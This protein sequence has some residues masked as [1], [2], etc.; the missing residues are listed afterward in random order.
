M[1]R[2]A[3]WRPALRIARRDLS[4]S[5]GRSSLVAV[6]VGLP[7]FLVST[8]ATVYTTSSLTPVEMLPRQLG[9][10]QAIVEP[11]QRGPIDQVPDGTNWQPV[12]QDGSS[13]ATE[14]W[15]LAQVRRAVA[16][17]VLDV[18]SAAG[19]VRTTS[20]RLAV[21]V[22]G[23]DITSPELTGYVQL[24]SGRM[25][26][27]D[28]EALVSPWLA[29]RG[30]AIGR[31]VEVV[32]SVDAPD[33][34]RATAKVVGVGLVPSLYA[35]AVVVARPTSP[36]VAVPD[37]EVAH[38]YLIAGS[39]PV[40]WP[41]VRE[42]N[43]VGLLVTSRSVVTNPPANWE[44]SLSR[45]DAFSGNGFGNNGNRAVL[46]I[47]VFS[48][49][50][51][52][53]LLAGPAFAVGVRRQRRHL[54]LVAAS[55]GTARDVRRVVLVQAL[56]TGALAAAVGAAAG[57]PAAW[58]IVTL[59]P[60]VRP[61]TSL[62]PFDVAGLPVLV[63]AA[64]G[65]V[66]AVTAAYFPAR[67][68]AR[69]DVVAVLAGRRGQ[70]RSRRGLPVLGVLL[71]GGGSAL[72]LLRGT[73][74]DGEYFVAG[75]TLVMVLGAIALMPAV[76]GGIGRLGR[77]LPLALRLATRDSAR[78]RG[79]TAPAVAAVMA[80]VAGVTT[81]AIGASSDFAQRRRDYQPRLPAGVT[82]VQAE[83]V[84]AAWWAFAARTVEGAAPGRRLLATGQL[85]DQPS[86]SPKQLATYVAPPGCPTTPPE[87]SATSTEACQQWQVSA[88]RERPSSSY[89]STPSLVADP[90]A[91]ALLGY[92]LDDRQRTVLE[93][94]GVL[95]PRA[96]LVD[97]AGYADLK[98][99]LVDYSGQTPQ[100]RDLR[101]QRVRAA[102]LPPRRLGG[103]LEVISVITTPTAAQRLGVAWQQTG[104]VLT[105]SSAPLPRAAQ[106]K[107]QEVLLGSARYLDVYTE[108]GF[109]E[110]LALPLL[111]LAV[112]AA[113]AVLVGTLTATGLALADSRPDAATLAA[114][115]AGPRTRRSMAAAQAVVIGLLGSLAG[116]AVGVVPGLAVTWPLTAAR[117][118][119]SSGEQVWGSPI[120]A[121][122]WLL[123]VGV[124]I[125]VPVLAA[126]AA[127]LGVRS[128]LP[129][130]RRLAQ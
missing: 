72:A 5:K 111:A 28:F 105:A 88:M 83:G 57:V 54:A 16:A 84:D 125:G 38:T 98:T 8:F 121:V 44:Q 91:L 52:V 96:G 6:M 74:Q 43:Q 128:R 124:G 11:V 82:T 107:V 66:A 110:S 2:L 37:G 50:L 30:F 21:R 71:L 34:R 51:E 39:Q 69:Q 78:Q 80:A 79:R 123:L 108:R 115:G 35:D 81:L 119:P 1:N 56:A 70:V 67:S 90:A 99:Y 14:P 93:Q 73:R 32:R 87:A 65:A 64:L 12:A 61:Q 97:A 114:V 106:D 53:V 49:L 25:P 130:T 58:L 86:S 95:L 18:T 101:S 92:R 22:V 109:D 36:V 94:G 45:P 40:T 26:R 3:G 29:S 76:V 102:V 127:G 55:G 85:G 75:G 13:G 15:T 20:G 120:I 113:L 59:L 117:S 122:P 7:V 9:A 89:V 100:V 17:P 129:L 103:A 126:L 31:D 68:A 47:V 23:A 62:G 19:T 116:I 27:N 33:V 60:K 63:A 46:V 10:T 77:H 104:G 48:I 112:I 41:R 42:L 118:D 4:R 24:R